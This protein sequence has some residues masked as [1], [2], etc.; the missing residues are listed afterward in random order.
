MVAEADS[1]TTD[2]RTDEA[3][4]LT[5]SYTDEATELACSMTDEATD[6]MTGA[7]L[8]SCTLEVEFAAAEDL[9]KGVEDEAAAEEDEKDD[10]LM[11]A[12]ELGV[13]TL[14]D[15]GVAVEEISATLDELDELALELELEEL[16]LDELELDELDDELDAFDEL[17]GV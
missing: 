1:L 13:I 12:I 15:D 8:D 3:T 17:D 7:E 9:T 4:E 16:T 14:L 2:G 11:V 10:R 5:S 6:L